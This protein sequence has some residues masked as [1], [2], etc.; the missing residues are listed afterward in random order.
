MSDGAA[1]AGEWPTIDWDAFWRAPLT[2]AD[3]DAM[4]RRGH[5]AAR[6]LGDLF[7]ERGVPD[8][9][10]SMG[11]GAAVVLLDLAEEFPDTEFVGYD[12]APAALE[13]A[14]ANH[15]ERESVD[16]ALAPEWGLAPV[17]FAAAGLP[18]PSIDRTFDV[19]YCLNTL[20]YVPDI[21]RALRDLFDLVAPGGVLV[22]NH[23]S[24]ARQAWHE[25]H[26]ADPDDYWLGEH[27]ER[28]L[29]RRLRLVDTGENVLARD[30]VEDLL[31]REA[32]PVGELLEGVTP[33][34]DPV[35]PV[36]SVEK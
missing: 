3:R 20:D 1:P 16:G 7:V 9:V 8:S 14:R 26:L 10:A 11:C 18:D 31:G 35:A 27:D 22:F 4:C 23:P 36:L 25:T 15:Q 12:P 5:D 32:R 21:E 19:V 34:P 17:T 13:R 33:N 24:P 28:W 2:P 30:R 29:R 6:L